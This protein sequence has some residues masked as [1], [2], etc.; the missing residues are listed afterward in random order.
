MHA[1][2]EIVCRNVMSWAQLVRFVSQV[3]AR[4]ALVIWRAFCYFKARR[5]WKFL[6]KIWQIRTH[7]LVRRLQVGG[8]PQTASLVGKAHYTD[9]RYNSSTEMYGAS[10]WREV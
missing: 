8:A 2:G 3:E 5:S 6:S 1:P 4:A 7:V 9:S 10:Y